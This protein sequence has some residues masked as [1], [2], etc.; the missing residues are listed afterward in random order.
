MTE[1]G[2]INLVREL[3]LLLKEEKVRYCHWK[4]NNAIGRS[5]TGDN[6]LDLLVSRADA[7]KFTEILFRLRFKQ[8]KA[9]A[10][11]QIPGILD[12]FGYDNAAD[13]FVHVHAHYRLVLGHDLAKNYRL[14]IEEAYLDSAAQDGLFRIPAP[15]FEFVVFTVRM[16]LKHCT[17]DLAFG[18]YGQ[19]KKAERDELAYLE[20]RIDKGRVAEVVRQFLPYI[21]V[22]LFN[23]CVAALEPGCTAWTRMR[24]AQRLELRLQASSRCGVPVGTLAKHWRRLG[25]AV[26]RR[27]S[28]SESK[29]RLE[30]GGAAIVIAG[31]D[32]S[33]K[34]T[35]VEALSRWLSEQFKTT[36]IHMGK[37]GWSLTTISA[38]AVLKVGQLL[39]LYPTETSLEETVKQK[40]FLSPG[41]PFLIRETCRARDRF[42]L[43]VKAQRFASKGG[44]VIF[45]RF[46]LPGIRLMDGPQTAWFVDEYSNGPE[47]GC[48]WSPHPDG[49]FTQFL[50]RLE[51]QYYDQMITPEL[52]VVLRLDPEIAVQRKADEDPISVRER[53]REIWEANWEDTGI[54]VIDASKSK[55]EVLNELKII[56]W[57]AL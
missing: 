56:I 13:K 52:T 4:S 34:S 54:H 9:P 5:A 37:P 23:S 7:P 10:E 24:I 2:A 18:S 11:K 6:D 8:A 14:P 49:R 12:Y 33:G 29:Y 47:A 35:A 21:G 31:G 16:V 53:N 27:I 41:Y 22:D 1:P 19:L 44:L 40:S 38:R 28:K 45:D 20:A 15:E 25:A 3:C 36:S 17:W 39:G 51:K 57:P 32:G 43:S 55:V 46:P 50:I 30:N 42:W 26:R 48:H